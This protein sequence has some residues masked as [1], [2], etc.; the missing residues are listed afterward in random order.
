MKVLLVLALLLGGNARVLADDS[1]T[2]K[3]K[4]DGERQLKDLKKLEV[5]AFTQGQMIG[6]ERTLVDDATLTPSEKAAK[7]AA[8]HEI[9]LQL[10][11]AFAYYKA[12]YNHD[13]MV[14][15]FDTE[16]R[17]LHSLQKSG[18]A[19]DAIAAQLAKI[20]TLQVPPLPASPAPPIPNLS[21]SPSA[22]SPH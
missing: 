19:P 5:I 18:A 17:M 20:D 2:Q 13:R 7:K 21:D 1:D 11:D 15:S 8:L 10:N 16:V 9:F 22:T 4:A 12:A 3:V 14:E 6:K